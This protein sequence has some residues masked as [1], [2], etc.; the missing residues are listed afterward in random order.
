MEG[1]GDRREGGGGVTLISSG[2]AQ[3]Q[4]LGEWLRPRQMAQER[5]G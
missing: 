4:Q 3:G 2:K 5:Q 1:V